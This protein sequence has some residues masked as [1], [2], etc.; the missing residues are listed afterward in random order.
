VTLASTEPQDDERG[1]MTT[2]GR[3]SVDFPGQGEM[4]RRMSD[5]DWSTTCVGP[6]GTWS[7]SLRTAVE[8]CLGSRFPIVIFW[9]REAAVLYNDAYRPMLGDRKHPQFIGRPAE[10]CWNEI[11]PTIGPMLAAVLDTGEATWSKDL[12]LPMVRNGFLEEAYFT[13]SYSPIPDGDGVGG[14]FCA[15]QETTEQVLGRRRLLVLRDLSVDAP[16]ADG[17]ARHAVAVLERDPLD[18]PFAV[19]AEA[20]DDGAQRILAATS[21]VASVALPDALQDALDRVQETGRAEMVDAAVALG[22]PGAG[23]WSEKPTSGYVLPIGRTSTGGQGGVVVGLSAGLAFDDAYR[24]FCSLVA[25]QIASAMARGRVREEEHQ[26]VEALA[27]ID[28][29]KTAFFS[30]VSHE[31]RTPLT[32]MLGPLADLHQRLAGTLGPEDDELLTMAERNG[33]RLLRLVNTLLDFSRIEAGRVAA[34]Y[35][36]VDLAADT[37]SVAAMF[38][39]AFERAG[40]ELVVDCPP[41]P[42]D[43]FV[44]REMWEKIVANLVSNA[45]KFTFEGSVTV[46]LRPTEDGGGAVLTVADTGVGVPAHEVPRLFERFHRVEGA[47]GRTHEGSGIGLALVHELVRMHGGRIEAASTEGVGTTI[48]VVVP[49]GSAHLARDRVR[50]REATPSPSVGADVLDEIL[51]WLPDGEARDAASLDGAATRSRPGPTDGAHILLADDNPD[52]REY[53]RRL[54]GERWV[55]TAVPDG[56]EALETARRDPPDLVVSDIM[57]PK[58]DG[59]GLLQALRAEPSTSGIPVILVSARAG[60]EARIE[61]LEAG[62][63]DYVVKPFSA[64]ELVARIQARLEIATAREGARLAAERER[65]AL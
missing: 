61:G 15:V 34:T 33:R 39:S 24:R 42:A 45:F 44:D 55:V 25:D 9:G 36:P 29:A 14:V 17:A 51:R 12:L 43:V 10:E 26:R 60:E 4:A 2:A 23:A 11:W 37:A 7:S 21:S 35:E 52:M 13:F 63:D 65:R 1:A 56:A 18:V 27:E 40:V 31:F 62:A 5:L 38:R 47:R 30:N 59:I 6:P 54:L 22:T 3:I 8:I 28:R 32:L 41:L 19:I 50:A 49:F 58:V 46:R 57:M 53:L 20:G 48:E 16:D 64:R